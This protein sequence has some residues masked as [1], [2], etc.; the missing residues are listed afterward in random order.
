M[1]SVLYD[2]NGEVCH[3]QH[4][5]PLHDPAEVPVELSELATE[6]DRLGIREVQFDP[7]VQAGTHRVEDD[8]D[9][10]RVIP[11]NDGRGAPL[12]LRELALQA[13]RQ[14]QNAVAAAALGLANMGDVLPEMRRAVSWRICRGKSI[15]DFILWKHDGGPDTA[16]DISVVIPVWNMEQYIDRTIRSVLAQKVRG[17]LELILVDNGSEDKGRDM[18]TAH[19]MADPRVTIVRLEHNLGQAVARNIGIELAR[20]EFIAP[21][22][23]DDVYVPGALQAMVSHFDDE[24]DCVHGHLLR[25][26]SDMQ[27]CLGPAPWLERDI[28]PRIIEYKCAIL[29]SQALI[30]RCA[31]TQK[32][33]WYAEY[34]RFC[35]DV[36]WLL[37][38]YLKC[39]LTFKRLRQVVLHRRTHPGEDSYGQ[40][41]TD[42]HIRWTTAIRRMVG[43][44][45]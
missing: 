24:T 30:R 7:D 31:F 28:T 38:A 2:K 1:I 45:R 19:A 11:K 14:R 27:H 5:N 26:D 18:M 41:V 17:G 33:A 39:G 23:A 16:P 8:E 20:G 43:A 34:C 40:R 9:G 21:F 15:E 13:H 32:G 44:T 37:H 3:V 36:E 4:T 10:T 22:D 12:L 25:F 35:E 6:L 42:N 29:P